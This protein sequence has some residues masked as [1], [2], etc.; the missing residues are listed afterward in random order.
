MWEQVFI[1]KEHIL[2]GGVHLEQKDSQNAVLFK[3]NT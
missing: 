3:S 1:F 2:T